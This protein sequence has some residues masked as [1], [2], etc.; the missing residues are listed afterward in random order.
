VVVGDEGAFDWCAGVPVVPDGGGEGQEPGGDAGVDPG[1]G[2][3]AVVFEGELPFEGVDDG[4]D[5]L[6]AAGELAEAGG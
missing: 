6:A 4:F 3:A 2:A 5:P 1:E